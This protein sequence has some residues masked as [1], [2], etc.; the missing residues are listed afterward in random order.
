MEHREI[1]YP[2]WV[3]EGEALFGA[4]RDNWKFVCPAC[5]NV[6]SVADYK[7]SE[8]PVGAIGF[9]CLG[10]FLP[11]C[12][13]AFGE[14]GPGPCDYSGGGVIGLNPV[15]VQTRPWDAQYDVMEFAR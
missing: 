2:E 6:A 15:R 4:D 3:A 10:R 14:K 12:R 8:A 9:S 7:A 5:G 13:R 11:H 1:T